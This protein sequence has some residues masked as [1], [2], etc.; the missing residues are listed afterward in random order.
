MKTIAWGGRNVRG[1]LPEAW[2]DEEG[3]ATALSGGTSSTSSICRGSPSAEAALAT[4]SDAMAGSTIFTDLLLMVHLRS[5]P[6][7]HES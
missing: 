2:S 7:L 1:G 3:S 4:R 5:I 6:L